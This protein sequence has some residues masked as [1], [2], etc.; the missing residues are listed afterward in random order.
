MKIDATLFNIGYDFAQKRT[1]FEFYSYGD[2]TSPLEEYLD[3]N[4]SLDLKREKRSKDANGMLW[5]LLG[6]LQN[7]LQ[8]PK[9]EIYREYIHRCGV[10]DVVPIKNE[11]LERFKDVW[12]SNGL[13]YVC[14]TTPSKLDGYTNVIAYY[15]TSTY[16]KDEMATLLDQVV[17]DCIEQ[18]IP[19]KRKEEIDSILEEWK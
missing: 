6:A 15:G 17:Q 16:S 5:S 13:G 11:A 10:Y 1:K 3:K 2:I 19:T 14:D 4:V 7:K 12:Q 18:G 8:I 9:E